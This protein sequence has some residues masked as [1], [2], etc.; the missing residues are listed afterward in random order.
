MVN[1]TFRLVFEL[2]V[3]EETVGDIRNIVEGACPSAMVEAIADFCD[4][5][6][7]FA[8][9][10]AIALMSVE[11]MGDDAGGGDDGNP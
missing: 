4:S 7:G 3:I 9:A 8:P 5:E 2:R 11:A 1:R 6:D 10:D